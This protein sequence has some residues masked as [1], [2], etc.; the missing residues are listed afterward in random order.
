MIDMVV[1][2]AM[3]R[4][5]IDPDTPAGGREYLDGLLRQA[6]RLLRAAEG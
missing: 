6:D 3:Y 2:A 4:M 5:L 1:G